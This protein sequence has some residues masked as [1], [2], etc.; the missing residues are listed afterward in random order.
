MVEKR[1]QRRLAAVLAADVVAYSRLMGADE[2]ARAA[3]DAYASLVPR[4]AERPGLI[5]RF[6]NE[7]DNE[8][9]LDGL[10]KA[11]LPE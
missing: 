5:W 3:L 1:V 7:S 6:K 11:G 10:R 9:F 8:H 4:K 2:D